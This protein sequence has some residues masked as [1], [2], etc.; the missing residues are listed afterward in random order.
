[1][2]G[3]LC[4]NALVRAYGLMILLGILH[5]E[6]YGFIN[7]AGYGTALALSVVLGIVTFDVSKLIEHDDNENV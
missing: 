6:V 5:A 4:V 3:V 2:I 1:M 7:P